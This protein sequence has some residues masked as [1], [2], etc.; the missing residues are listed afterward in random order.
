MMHSSDEFLPLESEDMRENAAEPTSPRF[1]RTSQNI[2]LARETALGSF[3]PTLSRCFFAASSS[4][5]Y[6]HCVRIEAA[7]FNRV[8]SV[9][10]AFLSIVRNM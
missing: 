10:I 1:V 9:S 5:A 8:A 6:D 7:A 3:A 2:E 4:S